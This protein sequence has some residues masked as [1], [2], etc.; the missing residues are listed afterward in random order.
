MR[1]REKEIKG[2][3]GR[4]SGGSEA[5]RDDSRMSAFFQEKLTVQEGKISLAAI[6][7]AVGSMGDRG[8]QRA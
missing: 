7:L 4:E 3:D 5:V 1:D 8:R 2:R 6:V